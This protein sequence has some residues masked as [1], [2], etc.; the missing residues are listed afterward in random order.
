MQ[1]T[2]SKGN[3]AKEPYMGSKDG[4]ERLTA[5]A[6]LTRGCEPF[7]NDPTGLSLIECRQMMSGD[8]YVG[9]EFE[10]EEAST[11]F[12]CE[13]ATR[14]G[15]CIRTNL[16]RRS[17]RDGSTIGL[18]FV[19]SREGF[20]TKKCPSKRPESRKGCKARIR[21]K[22]TESGKWAVVKFIKDH[23]HAL[24]TPRD[25]PRLRSHRQ[26]SNKPSGSNNIEFPLRDSTSYIRF[27]RR[28]VSGKDVETDAMIESLT[29]KPSDQDEETA[30]P[31][32][33]VG[34]EFESE[35]AATLFYC[36]YARRV[37]FSIR[38]S[39][40]RRSRRSGT[41][42]GLKFVCS[43]EGFRRQKS[44]SARRE[45]RQGCKAMIKMKRAEA[46]KWIIS[47]IMKEHNH[48][49]AVA[50]KV[51][52][53]QS[54]G[55]SSN[56]SGEHGGANSQER[57]NYIQN[58]R[59][60][61]LG[62]DAQYVI[63][64]FKHMQAKNA[65][66]FHAIQVDKEYRMTN[67]F[68]ADARARM[69]YNYFGDV[70]TLDTTYRT[71]QYG[72]PFALF[73]GVNHHKQ[74]VLFGCALL[75]DESE[76]SFVWL[77]NTW[78]E[79]MSGQHPFSL[80]TDQDPVIE[81]AVVKVFPRTRHRFCKRNILRKFSE[82]SS[83]LEQNQ[84]FVA[85]FAKCINL[86]E[87][88]DEF[89]S[90]WKSLID[91]YEL[92]D[93]EWLQLLYKSRDKWVQ[94]YL[95]DTSFVN[96]SLTRQSAG[97]N[98]FFDGYM[99]A[100]TSLQAFINQCEKFIDSQ[101]EM[102]LEDDF[103][104]SYTKPIMKTG[105]PLES[106]AAEI[107]TRTIFLE[108]QEQ[109]FQSLHHIAEITKEDGPISTLRVVEFGAEKR[110]YTVK[111]DVTEERASCS[112]KMFE[113]AGILCRHVLRVFSMK[114]ITLLPS[115][116]ILKRWTKNPM[117]IVTFDEDEAEIQVDCQE[118]WMSRYND[119]CRQAIKYAGEAATTINIYNVAMRALRKAFEE[120]DAA[121]LDDGILMDPSFPVD[122]STCKDGICEGNLPD[123]PMGDM[124]SSEPRNGKAKRGLEPARDE[125]RK[126]KRKCQICQHP[127]HDKRKCPYSRGVGA[128]SNAADAILESQL[129]GGLTGDQ[130][131]FSVE[132]PVPAGDSRFLRYI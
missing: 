63:E 79:A 34:M 130:L 41:T 21:I 91:K 90:C 68:W 122:G 25:L 43:K 1:G 109:L 33:E 111:F 62:R 114:N 101:Y 100:H 107:Y 5:L 126:K 46:G 42:I 69:A 47:D 98:S 70:V 99:N 51:P 83:H 13:Y 44:T 86:T 61:T 67:F 65:S 27:L 58:L 23:N 22:K 110:P 35:E 3:V 45:T 37:G 84:D 94:V 121:K 31:D 12:Y 71:N 18:E 81:A 95:Q 7:E 36:E 104:T 66:F 38:T 6:V 124:S 11:E 132:I 60:K 117:S 72:I 32:P 19:C 9:M 57:A 131:G 120:V 54:H 59:E 40:R 39:L 87:L 29:G 76:A 103:K 80:I 20:R 49:F 119:L 113:Y 30:N 17:R 77:F 129:H 112:C 108:F 82:R 127:D 2:R 24:D 53:L 14:V 115:C 75:L 92:S 15:F 88:N 93:N 125:Q 106:Q 97:I 102:E 10:S 50:K 4:T 74:P 89:E 64:Y 48:A 28:R 52:L 123:Q 55:P 26:G 116:Y 128:N 105:L 78:V 118:S 8:P 96:I 73:T 56:Q 16:R 85:D